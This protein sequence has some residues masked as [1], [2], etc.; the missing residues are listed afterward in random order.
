MSFSYNHI[1]IVGRNTKDLNLQKV[2]E[3]SKLKIDLAVDRPYRKEDGTC[4]TDFIPCIIWGKLAEIAE[5]YIRKGS[6]CLIEGRLQI[7]TWGEGD[8]KKWFTEVLV[9]NFQILENKPS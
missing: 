3:S 4:E 9:E 1:T 8:A 5:K 7:K 2:G 6:P